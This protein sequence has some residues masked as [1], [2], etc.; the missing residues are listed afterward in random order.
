[1]NPQGANL[2][3]RLAGLDQESS[4]QKRVIYPRTIHVMDIHANTEIL[5]GYPLHRS[6]VFHLS[7]PYFS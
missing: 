7:F 2:I 5:D 6:G 3:D 1:M 4:G